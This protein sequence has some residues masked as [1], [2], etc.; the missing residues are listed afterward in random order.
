MLAQGAVCGV[1]VGWLAG[2][3]GGVTRPDFT[4]VSNAVAWKMALL[5]FG[6]FQAGLVLGFGLAQPW[7]APLDFLGK[8]LGGQSSE[9]SFG[10]ASSG[11]VQKGFAMGARGFMWVLFSLV[12][13]AVMILFLAMS[14]WISSGKKDPEAQQ[15]ETAQS[16]TGS[17]SAPKPKAWMNW[18][19]WGVAGFIVLGTLA[20]FGTIDPKLDQKVAQGAFR[21]KDYDQALHFARRAVYFS[22]E[23][24]KV[25]SQAQA[26]AARAAA[27]AGNPEL[28][29]GYLRELLAKSPE[30]AV[31]YMLRA[32]IRKQAGELKPALDDLNRSIELMQSQGL[33][34][35]DKLNHVY[36]GQAESGAT[37]AQQPVNALFG[38]LGVKRLNQEN[39]DYA[40]A[41]SLRGQVN[42]ALAELAPARRDLQAAL[43]LDGMLPEPHY[44]LSL[45]LEKQGDLALAVKH[46][47]RALKLV[48]QAE[49]WQFKADVYHRKDWFEHLISLKGRLAKAQKDSKAKQTQ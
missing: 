29:D 3:I 8:V 26:V 22:E 33:E 32:Q 15:T 41:L 24:D 48:S 25:W 43:A 35:V 7:F 30:S 19:G 1:L 37:S 44:Q 10:I 12:D 31:G 27:A 38:M 2:R 14:P 46:C 16:G 45:V 40:D 20:D 34:S 21:A 13:W 18:L 39:R 17:E 28:A 4:E 47:Q 49:I 23:A 11:G 6:V 5:W 9:Y 42:L 36:S